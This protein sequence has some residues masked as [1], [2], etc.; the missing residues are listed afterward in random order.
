MHAHP[1]DVAGSSQLSQD[2]E[3]VGQ[4]LDLLGQRVAQLLI[5]RRAD[6]IVVTEFDLRMTPP[7]AG[8]EI[9]ALGAARRRTG[10][11]RIE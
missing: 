6:R 5:G 1:V 10:G 9:L 11:P 3:R 2:V 8:L 4:V 7:D